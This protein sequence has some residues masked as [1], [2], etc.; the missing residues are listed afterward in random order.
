[1]E[2]EPIVERIIHRLVRRHIA[3]TTM[4]SALEAAKSL[5]GRN[6]GASITFLSSSVLDKPKA[7]YITTTYSELVRRIARSGIKAGV[8]VPLEQVGGA[9]DGSAALENLGDILATASKYGVFVWVDPDGVGTA[10]ADAVAGRKGVG[11]AVSESEFSSYSRYGKTVEAAKVHFKEYRP[12]RKADA[13][14]RLAEVRRAY[15]S[16]VLAHPT[17]DMLS[18]VMKCRDREGLSLEFGLGYGARKLGKVAVGGL[19]V[20]ELVPFGKDW[21][22]YATNNAPEGYMRF[23]AA[24]LLK[25]GDGSVA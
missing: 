3:G 5:I 12:A 13:V 2:H 7:K 10:A 8:Q 23:V 25:D 11:L 4:D 6:I 14:K 17:E 21:I 22:K 15:G 9:I 16:V 18:A 20:S 19:K 24:K 1:M